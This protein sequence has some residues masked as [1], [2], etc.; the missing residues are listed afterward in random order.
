[1]LAGGLEYRILFKVLGSSTAFIVYVPMS[2]SSRKIAIVGRKKK[3]T[4]TPFE[5][6]PLDQN[7]NVWFWH[8]KTGE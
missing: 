3:K 4:T 7:K 6:E 2:S 5:V 1:M 8:Q